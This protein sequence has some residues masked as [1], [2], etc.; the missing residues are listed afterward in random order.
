MYP[1]YR[2]LDPFGKLPRCRTWPTAPLSSGFSV[3][4]VTSPPD[5]SIF[6]GSLV[7]TPKGPCTYLGFKGVPISLLWALCILC[8][9]TWTPG[10]RN[11]P[12]LRRSCLFKASVIMVLRKLMQVLDPGQ[13]PRKRLPPS[14]GLAINIKASAV[15]ACIPTTNST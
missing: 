11:L 13:V 6:G 15:I 14:S 9:G 10:A 3:S 12:P 4:P 8:N 7:N 2:Y 5:L 1:L